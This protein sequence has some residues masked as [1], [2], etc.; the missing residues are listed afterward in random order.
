MLDNSS[1]HGDETIARS[2]EEGKPVNNSNPFSLDDSSIGIGILGI[3][4]S[5]GGLVAISQVLVDLP[6]DFPAPIL[7]L[8]HLGRGQSNLV[9]IL[10][11]KSALQVHWASH[12]DMPR[13]A[14][15]SVAP[16]GYSL[17]I[18]P[19]G[20]ISLVPVDDVIKG[21]ETASSWP[22]ADQFLASLAFSYGPRVLAVI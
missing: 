13:P 12:G 15:V 18:Y 9:K 14:T 16:P 20:T 10:G 3:V 22:S 5:F 7:V 21:D 6:A 11:R 2:T 1:N 4:A 19:D 8:Q 17:H